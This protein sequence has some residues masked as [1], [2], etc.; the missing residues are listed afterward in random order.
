MGRSVPTSR[1]RDRERDRNWAIVDQSVLGQSIPKGSRRRGAEQF[2]GG[3]AKQACGTETEHFLAVFAHVL[4]R[5]RLWV[6]SEEY[7]EWLNRTGGMNWL[8]VAGREV[9]RSNGGFAHARTPLGVDVRHVIPISSESAGEADIT[10]TTG[11]VTV[12]KKIRTNSGS[13]PPAAA[14][15][16]ITC[17]QRSC[18]MAGL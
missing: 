11:P 7:A 17:R 10:A 8:F 2:R 12:S 4:H 16:T 18:G 14:F 1:Y 9:G 5:E 3:G 13:S 15:S 6:K